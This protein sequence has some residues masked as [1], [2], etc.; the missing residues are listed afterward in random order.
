ML[1]PAV[2]RVTALLWF[3]HYGVSSYLYWLRSTLW[4]VTNRS[5]N[6]M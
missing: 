4:H 5:A 2:R 6:W 3:T 1:I